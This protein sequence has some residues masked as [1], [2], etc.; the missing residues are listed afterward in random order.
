MDDE[1]TMEQRLLRAI[2]GTPDVHPDHP[3]STYACP[4]DA[5]YAPPGRGHAEDCTHPA[6]A[7][8]VHVLSRHRDGSHGFV[9]WSC[10]VCPGVFGGRATHDESVAAD[11]MEHVLDTSVR[12]AACS[13]GKAKYAGSPKFVR[14]RHAVHVEASS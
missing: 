9:Y 12:P 1:L 14:E 10:S 11:E 13:C 5:R 2:F 7:E 6:T 8:P 3:C 4:G